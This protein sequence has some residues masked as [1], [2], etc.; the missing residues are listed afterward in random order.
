[1][2]SEVRIHSSRKI[3]PAIMPVIQDFYTPQ[4]F[5]P[6]NITRSLIPITSYYGIHIAGKV[7]G[8]VLG[9]FWWKLASSQ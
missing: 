7:R 1:M 2:R 4:R 9:N 6:H 3:D 5:R 8:W